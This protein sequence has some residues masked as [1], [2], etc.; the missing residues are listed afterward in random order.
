MAILFKPGLA[1]TCEASIPARRID[2]ALSYYNSID[3]LLGRRETRYFG[4]GYINTT[5]SVSDFEWRC[6]I[7]QGRGEAVLTFT[8]NDMAVTL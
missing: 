5:R 8:R 1:K 3:D 6:C 4:N 7:N 2:M